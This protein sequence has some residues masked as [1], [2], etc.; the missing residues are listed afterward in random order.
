MRLLKRLKP[1]RYYLIGLAVLSAGL[2]FYGLGRAP[3]LGPDEPRYAEV[4]REMYESGDWITPRLG[5][6]HWFE[7][8]ALLYW[9]VAASYEA[10]GV[11]E[12]STRLTPALVASFGAWLLYFFGRRWRSSRFGYLSAATLLSSGLWIGFGRAATFDTPLSVALEL[13][14]IAFF[15]WDQRQNSRNQAATRGAHAAWWVC[16]FALGLAVLAKGLVGILLPAAIIGLYLIAT[17]GLGRWLKQPRLLVIGAMVFLAT[18][19]AWYGPMLAQHGHEFI[20]EFFIAHHFQRFLTNKYHHPQP[21]YFFF[22]VAL[23]GAFPWSLF[24]ATAAWRAIKGWRALIGDPEQRWRLYL[25]LW[26]LVPVVF[27]SFS[28]SKLPGYILP[29]FPAAALIIGEELE[30]WWVEAHAPRLRR[31][32]FLTAALMIIVALG[33]GWRG[34]SELG[35]SARAAWITA[36]L[37]IAVAVVYLALILRSSGEAA[38]LFLPFG[39]TVVIMAAVHLL[40]PG[41][42]VRESLRELSQTAAQA[43]QPSERLAFYIDTEQ[44]LNFYA[45]ALPLRD[46]RS[47]LVTVMTPSEIVALIEVQSTRTLLVISRQ[48]WSPFLVYDGRMEAERLGEQ[49]DLV[50]LR[51]RLRQWA[52]GSRQWTVSDER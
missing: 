18:A 5:G 43:A 37:A 13:A 1:E 39:L 15:L 38:T 51:I 24:L 45:P 16:C 23:I 25:W 35:V 34:A 17:R 48:R 10:L 46:A 26:V 4:A 31:L 11:S 3:L 50:L 8:P 30:Q 42:G 49:R 27:F 22:V 52:V 28:I 14:L 9:M 7:K 6:I 33:V 40:L 32:G 47:E 29:I 12:L 20:R 21:F 19:S 41:L 36:G 2:L 44:S